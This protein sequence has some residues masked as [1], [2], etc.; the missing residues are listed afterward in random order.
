MAVAITQTA[1]PVS[2]GSG[3]TVTYSGVSTGVAAADRVVAVAVTTELTAG[4]ISSATIDYGSGAVAMSSSTNGAQGAVGARMFWLSVP[5]G[6]TADIAIT[7]AASQTAN[8]QHITVYRA[9]GASETASSSGSTG[10]TDADPISSGALT[11]PTGGGCIAVC[12]MAATGVRTWAGITEGVDEG[13]GATPQYQHTTGTSTTAGTPTITVSGANAEDGALAWLILKPGTQLAIAAGSYAVTGQDVTLQYGKAIAV[14]GGSYALTGQTV[15]LQVPAPDWAGYGA[16]PYAAAPYAGPML[17]DPTGAAALSI[18]VDAGSYTVSG[19]DVALA[20]GWVVAVDG[21]SYSVTGQDVTLT[22]AWAVPVD[23]GSYAVTGQDVS[24]TK[25]WLLDV[26]AGSYAITGQDVALSVGFAVAVDA[27]SYSITGQDVTL[28]HDFAIPIDAGSYSVSGQDVTLTKT[29]LLDVDAGSYAVTGQDVEL[30]KASALSIAVDAGSYSITG[31]DIA[32]AHQWAMDVDSGGYLLSGQDVE[33]TLGGA[34]VAAAGGYS[35]PGFWTE[36][37]RK[38]KEREEGVPEI[39]ALSNLPEF[40][41]PQT[42]GDDDEEDEL[43]ELME[44]ME[45]MDHAS[46]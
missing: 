13:A 22:H 8:T 44:L 35:D 36:E 17:D 16:V 43:S 9:V 31:Q 29:W 40:T 5:T 4:A 7:F 20:H 32:L 15:L 12:A 10:D 19:Q 34:A 42:W 24:L 39:E 38:I 30:T 2:A 45:I 37:H 23:A 46:I 41:V 11:I 21:A 18:T 28:V 25:T 33:L 6:T 27:G 26:D 3:T 1:N 14:D